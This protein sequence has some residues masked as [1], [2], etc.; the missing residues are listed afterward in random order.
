MSEIAFTIETEIVPERRIKF[1][2]KEKENIKR[3][4]YYCKLHQRKLK[5]CFNLTTL[6]ST[7]VAKNM[8]KC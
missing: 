4:P 6:I 2:Q 3:S 7:K 8:L 1:I 5:S